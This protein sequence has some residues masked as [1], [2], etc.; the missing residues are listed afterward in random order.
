M[1][2]VLNL[3]TLREVLVVDVEG[4]FTDD[5]REWPDSTRLRPA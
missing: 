1:S 5:A 2:S 3:R 4:R